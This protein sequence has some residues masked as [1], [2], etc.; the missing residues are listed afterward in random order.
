MVLVLLIVGVVLVLWP[1]GFTRIAH[2]LRPGFPEKSGAANAAARIAGTVLIVA[3]L[4]LA[5]ALG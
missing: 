1:G 5:L 3:A 4:L 2:F